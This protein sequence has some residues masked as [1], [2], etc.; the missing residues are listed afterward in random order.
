MILSAQI[1]TLGGVMKFAFV[2]LSLLLSHSAFAEQVTGPAATPADM[3]E[4]QLNGFE[5]SG[6]EYWVFVAG[7]DFKYPDDV[8]WSFT[9]AAPEQAQACALQAYNKLNALLTNPPADFV[10]LKDKGATPRFYLWTNDYTQSAADEEQ[11][12]AKFWHWNR[13][14]KNYS[15]GYWKW[16]SSVTREGVC[17]IPQ[18]EQIREMIKDIRTKMG[19]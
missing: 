6:S 11:R 12:P 14:P 10:E 13:G 16:E 8:I 2:F 5:L 19:L 7:K 9:G 1:H 18:D 3:H 17:T 15:Q 4:Y